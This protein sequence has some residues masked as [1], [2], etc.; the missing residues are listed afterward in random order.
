MQSHSQL[1]YS[2]RHI[3]GAGLTDGEGTE[4]FWSFMVKFCSITKGMDYVNRR[5]CI[6]QVLILLT[7]FN[8]VGKYMVVRVILL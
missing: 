5:V 2:P 6:N 7:N 4:R 3:E 8:T 1:K